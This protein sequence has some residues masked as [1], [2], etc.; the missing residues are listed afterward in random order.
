MIS[1]FYDALL[2]SSPYPS[3]PRAARIMYDDSGGTVLL[4]AVVE[5]RE[6][7]SSS[8][9][10]S[11]QELLHRTLS[12]T[13]PGSVRGAASASVSSTRGGGVGGGGAGG[14]K[15]KIAEEAYAH[16]QIFPD[17]DYR[18]TI[19]GHLLVLAETQA[20]AEDLIFNFQVGEGARKGGRPAV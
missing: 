20:A 6:P 5:H 17:D 18:F 14:S 4:L 16:V 1:A 19:D 9:A 11:R 13:G 2:P 7:T 3:T 15:K 10:L 12:S 8:A